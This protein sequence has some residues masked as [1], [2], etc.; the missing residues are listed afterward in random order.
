MPFVDDETD[1]QA[2]A[3]CPSLRFERA[4]FTTMDR[5]SALA[6]FRAEDG[7]RYLQGVPVCVHPGRIGLFPEHISPP[8]RPL[9]ELAPPRAARPRR[10]WWPFG[11]RP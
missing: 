8:P 9:E 7:Y 5:P 10:T 6:P 2:C 1:H 11:R 3:T 4:D